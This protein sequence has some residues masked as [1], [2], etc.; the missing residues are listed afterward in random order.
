VSWACINL[1]PGL[2]NHPKVIQLETAVGEAALAYVLRLWCW[3]AIDC[4]DGA[5]T[6]FGNVNFLERRIMRWEGESGVLLS[7]MVDAEMIEV[8]NGA[9]RIRNWNSHNPHL[10]KYRERQKAAANARWK[11]HRA[12]KT[13]EDNGQSKF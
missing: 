4:P 2:P 11:K 1:D 3:A 5:L 10:V 6:R 12:A 13:E 7:A 9:M 8:S